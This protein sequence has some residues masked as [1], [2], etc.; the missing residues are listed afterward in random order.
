MSKISSFEDLHIWQESMSIATELYTEFKDCK[1]FAYRDQILRA[2][3]S[4]P[5]NIAEGFERN[6][7]K[8]FYNFLR[9]AK[10]SAGEVRTQIIFAKG[11]KLMKEQKADG[12]ISLLKTLSKQIQTL[13]SSINGRLGR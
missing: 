9:Y 1:D 8:D 6:N 4:V 3:L 13:M 10:G 11:V 5:L 7:N 12:Y 2:S